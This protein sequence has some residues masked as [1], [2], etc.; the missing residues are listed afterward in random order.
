MVFARYAVRG[1]A[2][3]AKPQAVIQGRL[4]C[5]RYQR[6]LIFRRRTTRSPTSLRRTIADENECFYFPLIEEAFQLFGNGRIK[7][8]SRFFHRL[9]EAP[10]QRLDA[11]IDQS[12]SATC[13]RR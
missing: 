5:C 13:A 1:F 7:L 6:C 10:R 8:H 2:S 9:I 3:K 4:E 12:G 11:R